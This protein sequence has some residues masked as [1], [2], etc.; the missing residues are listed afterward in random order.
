[1][2]LQTKYGIFKGDITG[3]YY[4]YTTACV[5]ELQKLLKVEP[6]SGYFGPI[7]R[8]ALNATL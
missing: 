1:M 5:K 3:N 8:K 6:V 7:T 2:L 4:G